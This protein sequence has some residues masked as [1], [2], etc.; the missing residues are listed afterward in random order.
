MEYLNS[1]SEVSG[2]IEPALD[3]AVQK[4]G[5]T[6]GLTK[7]E[8]TDLNATIRVQCQGGYIVTQ[9]I[10]SFTDHCFARMAQLSLFGLN[11]YAGRWY[12]E[13]VEV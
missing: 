11:D 6:T 2:V 13:K 7:G 9:R 12:V 10:F 4:S 8:I 1:P 3:M 5:R